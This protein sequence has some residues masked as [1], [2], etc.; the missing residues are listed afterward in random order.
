[1]DT[2]ANRALQDAELHRR[3]EARLAEAGLDP[4][5]E[6]KVHEVQVMQ[7]ELELQRED[8]AE[9]N[10]R[11]R[12]MRTEADQGQAELRAANAKLK[13]DLGERDRAEARARS[14][15]KLYSA[16]SQTN[17]AILRVREEPAL[18]QKI[19]DIASEFGELILAWIGLEDAEARELRVVAGSGPALGY[20]DGLRF[21]LD[22]GSVSGRGP[23]LTAM[24]LGRPVVI[25]DFQVDPMTGSWQAKASRHGIGAS[26][27][28]PIARSGRV[29]GA[30]VVYAQRPGFFD[31][32]QVVLLEAMAGA[33]TFALEALDREADRR[34]TEEKFTRMF[35]LCPD[36]IDLADL[37]TGEIREFNANFAKL[38]GFTSE[39]IQGR[40]TL[41]GGLGILAPEDRARHIAELKADRESLG[42]ELRLR[43]KDGST[44][45]GMVSS[46]LL[47]IGGSR[48]CIS[49]TR[50]ISER[51]QAEEALVQERI[52]T[53]ALLDNL[54]EGVLACDDQ[55]H[56]V[57][58]NRTLREWQGLQGTDATPGRGVDPVGHQVEVDETTPMTTET[59]PL[60]RAFNGEVFRDATMT[61]RAPG[62]PPRH[63]HCNGSPILDPQNRRLGAVVV[64]HDVTGQRRADEDLRKI[65]VAMAQSPVS[66]VITDAQGAIEYV[67]PKFTQLTGYSAA[68][69]LGQNPRVLK[70]GEFP[71]ESYA[72]LWA[73]IT[74]GEIWKGEFHNRKK[75]GEL[76]WEAA[77]IAPIK[78]GDGR[79]TGFVALKEDI[80]ERQQ[81]KK[82]L[83]QLNA[84]LE[85][86]VHQ[87]T[88]LL[89]TAN[90]ELDAFS[91]SVSHDLRA[92]LRGI[93]GFSLALLEECGEGLSDQA[94]HYL[95]R[96][97]AGTQRMGQLIDDLLQL[98]RVSRSSLNSRRLDLSAL[99]LSLLEEI[100]Q[101]DPSRGLE[102]RVE[103]GLVARGDRGLIRSVLENVLG[104]AWKYTAK[105]PQARI[106]VFRT[107]LPDGGTAFCVRDNG[108][109]FDMAHAGKLFVPFQRLHSSHDY[110]GTGIGLAIVQR[111]IQRH[112]GEIWAEAEVGKGATFYLRLPD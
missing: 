36:A 28:F 105:V 96:V 40:T 32:E 37:D 95:Q 33:L 50:D 34:T 21:D 67:N 71:P 86:R 61:V 70:S 27:S 81:A 47:E 35:Q 5:L 76:F 106:E 90:A 18:F 1:M 42:R 9:Q 16:L 72:R 20:L 78:A 82:L 65:S 100:R 112:G 69:V 49:I 89:E 3:A 107:L 39:E 23:T 51:K 64:M 48:Y 4:G 109:G 41:P 98:S 13:L 14:L 111:I 66:V 99:A 30:L 110:E 7:V 15:W 94:K 73:T 85:E 91:Y 2:G 25:N 74:G 88:A 79:I 104:N 38:Y 11:L 92:P 97:R 29:V 60:T 19:C 59:Y 58:A 62:Q 77:T 43:R 55:G 24:R 83:E 10:Q 102:I 75:D 26:A 12:Q 57:L 63:L 80:T 103:E 31:P 93:D 45:T 52:F 22:P 101:A 46:A 44:F 68:E 53:R 6:R 17:H 56:P 8:L 54:V 84:E 108:A 87:R